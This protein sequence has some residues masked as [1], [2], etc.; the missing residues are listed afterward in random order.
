MSEIQADAQATNSAAPAVSEAGESTSAASPSSSPVSSDQPAVT[1]ETGESSVAPSS[2]L[3]A[4]AQPTQSTEISRDSLMS[5]L[6]AKIDAL[7]AKI[8]SG[9]VVFAHEVAEI[10]AHIKAVL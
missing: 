4:Q 6:H 5:R 3:G 8:A 1:S 9:V 10:R 7:E 2:T